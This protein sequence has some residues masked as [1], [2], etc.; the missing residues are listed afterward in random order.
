MLGLA[1]QDF[2]RK[3]TGRPDRVVQGYVEAA[4]SQPEIKEIAPRVIEKMITDANTKMPPRLVTELA[5]ETGLSNEDALACLI[6]LER[7]GLTRRLNELWEISHD[8]VARQFALLLG[9][10]RPNPWRKIGMFAAASLFMLT[11]VGVVIGVP[12]FVQQQAFAALRS[13]Q[14]SV[15]EGP[16]GKLFARFPQEATNATIVSALPALIWLGVNS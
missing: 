11:L 13:L 12:V 1:L 3:V 9:R 10:L 16:D 6:L 2:D 8:F 5:K 14:I 4:I 15:A 7:K